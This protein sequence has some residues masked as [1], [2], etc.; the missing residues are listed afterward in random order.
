MKRKSVVL[1]GSRFDAV[2][3]QQIKRGLLPPSKFR[4]TRVHNVVCT[5]SVIESSKARKRRR[6][7]AKATEGSQALDLSSVVL[8]R[9]FSNYGKN[10]F[11]A[12]TMKSFEETTALIFSPGKVLVGKCASLICGIA[13]CH[14]YRL[15]I[16]YTKQLQQ[17]KEGVVFTDLTNRLRFDNFKV[18][19][20]VAVGHFGGPVDVFGISN[21]FGAEWR[22]KLFQGAVLK[23]PIVRKITKTNYNVTVLIFP[24][25]AFPIV[26]APTAK[27]AHEV[28]ILMRKGI[29]EK[30]KQK[31]EDLSKTDLS[32]KRMDTILMDKN[33]LEALKEIDPLL[34]EEKMGHQE[35]NDSAFMSYVKPVNEEEEKQISRDTSSPDLEI[36]TA[37]AEKK[38]EIEELIANKDQ[39][40]LTELHLAVLRGKFTAMKI[41]VSRGRDVDARTKQGYT[42]MDLARIVGAF[43][44]QDA[45]TLVSELK[46]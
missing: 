22:P 3:H 32:S 43:Y 33:N 31:K 20:L 41:L 34:Y 18:N 15:M 44:G 25:G 21:E 10:D 40:G 14:D 24:S 27:V 17:T 7:G 37:R 28:A 13:A 16:E 1:D 45:E 12:M 46:E 2:L 39:Y 8:Q 26:A 4:L 35:V 38:K 11:A 6:K 42:L 5:V 23:P 19:N 9:P 36:D 30:Y 29:P